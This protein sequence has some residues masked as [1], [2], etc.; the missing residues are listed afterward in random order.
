MSKNI[1][2]DLLHQIDGLELDGRLAQWRKAMKSA[3]YSFYAD[4]ERLFMDSWKQTE[5][6]DI[7]IRRAMA[8][9]HICENIPISILPHELIVGKPTPGVIGA[10]PEIDICGDY[11]KS[12][13][14]D[15]DDIK[16]GFSSE[17]AMSM[18]TKK[19]MRDAVNTFR[20]H[21]VVDMTNK[22]LEQIYGSWNDDIV[23]SKAKD[24]GLDAGLFASSTST[25]DF[26]YILNKGIGDYIKR[27][28]EY[29]AAETS[30][31]TPNITR[32][33]FWKA[34][35]L[36]MEGIIML[37]H[38]YA[39]LARE[40]AKETSDNIRKAELESIFSV[41]MKVPEKPAESLQEALTAMSII[42]AGKVLEH[43]MHNYP[44]W[45]RG[46]QYLYPFFI[47]DINSEKI[48]LEDAAQMI[49]E[50]LG[51]WGTAL[52]VQSEAFKESHQVNFGINNIVLGGYNQNHEDASNE[53]SYLFLHVTAMLKLSSPTVSIRWT[54][55]I[56]DWMMDK[57]ISCNMETRGG[58][59]LFEN[60]E[61]VINHF[62][63]AG[64]PYNEACE[65]VG[66]GCVYPALPSRAEHYGMEGLAGLN[67]AAMLH[68]ALHNGRDINGKLTGV[69]CGD[70]KDFESVEQIMDAL[71]TQHKYIIDRIVTLAH[72]AIDVQPNYFRQPF[73]STIAVP[74]YFADGRDLLIPDHTYTQFGFSDRAIIDTA[75][76]I[77]AIKHIVFD[78]KKLTM[79]ELM[80]VLDSNFDGVRGEEVRQMCLAAPKFGNDIDE[81]DNLVSEI[82]DRSSQYIMHFDNSPFRPLMVAREGLAWHYMAG[83]GVGALPDGRKALEPLDDGSF[84][85]MGG[86]D[87]NGPTAVLR[88]VL[89]AK[90]KDSYATVLNQKFTSAILKSDESKKLLTQY[91]SAFMAAG[92][93]HVQ[94]NIVDTEELKTAQ[95]IPDNYKDLIVRVGGFS[96]YFTQLSAG[97]QNDVINRSENAL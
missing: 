9:K 26:S 39:E 33:Y 21:T 90:M 73:W 16:F 74:Y 75:D 81:V 42:G 48:T 49:G 36:C 14:S 67:L 63:S 41:C 62:V 85:P 18:D 50:L 24:P 12:I 56:P 69:D 97:I 27:A 84:S 61:S 3:K 52:F 95:R 79:E 76:S 40:Q 70:A 83:L 10:L 22:A 1:N 30:K 89:K 77:M 25:C 13:W 47:N 80:N 44:Q 71:F 72:V 45:G 55:K 51:R 66:L 20:G 57:A 5:D 23:A 15:E 65:W 93:T 46:D 96:A 34:S 2:M 60:D 92:G 28:D 87:K 58:I 78:E 68:M 32:I 6:E 37:A 88:S 29:I 38:R 17:A 35:K 11:I 7:E 54:Q 91:T 53:L 86:A 59:P 19:M 82:S 94:Y 43:P 4:R 8:F 31:H 64:I